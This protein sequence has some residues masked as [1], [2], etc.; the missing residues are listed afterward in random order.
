MLLS[1]VLQ[2][3]WRY[4]AL[5]FLPHSTFFSSGILFEGMLNFLCGLH[6]NVGR[7]KKERVI[8]T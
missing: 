2:P 3:Y 7:E 5:N 6:I 1:R 4:I 8:D